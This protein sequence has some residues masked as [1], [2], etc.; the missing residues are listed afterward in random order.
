M[1]PT[2]ITE[3]K[4]QFF[5]T[6]IADIYRAIQGPEKTGC[7]FSA[8]TLS[9]CSI[10]AMTFLKYGESAGGDEFKDWVEEYMPNYEKDQKIK[11]HLIEKSRIL[12][13]LRS[14]MVHA[15]GFSKARDGKFYKGNYKDN[16]P[17]SHWKIEETGNDVLC[18]LNLESHLAEVTLGAYQFF[19]RLEKPENSKTV[20]N[21]LR[22]KGTASKISYVQ[23][24]GEMRDIT[25]FIHEN[26][27]RGL[28]LPAEEVM[29]Y[30]DYLER[31]N[32]TDVQSNHVNTLT[33]KIRA[34]MN[35]T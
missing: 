13:A 18:P 19:K 34:I 7:R 16:D 23:V 26:L 29:K 4:F 3:L 21:I 14:E 11:E 27:L 30:L 9:M 12:W 5:H 35:E 32:L 22:K 33:D 24:G 15:H 1:L 20:Q 6:G 8:F 10:D 2:S 28:R 17:D 31:E 25:H